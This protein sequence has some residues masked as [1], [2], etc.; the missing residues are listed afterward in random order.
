MNLEKI[1]SIALLVP[2]EEG[3]GLPCLFEGPPGVGKSARIKTAARVR[4]LPFRAVYMPSKQ[5]EDLTGL[6][7]PDRKGEIRSVCGL[8]PVRELNEEG[9]GVLLFDEVNWATRATQSALLSVVL[10]RQVGDTKIASGVRLLLAA[11]AADEGDGGVA[12]LTTLAN[13]VAHFRV[14]KPSADEYVAFRQ[15]AVEHGIVAIADAERVVEA[16]WPSVYPRLNGLLCGFFKGRGRDLVHQ[17]PPVGAKARHRG[18]PSPRSWDAAIR[19]A[20]TCVAL[21]EEALQDEFLEACVGEGAAMEF[22]EFAREADLPEPAAMLRGD[23]APD[24][25]RLDICVAAYAALGEHV[26]AQRKDEQR[27]LAPRT[28]RLFLEACEAG[29][30]DLIAAPAK[31]LAKAGLDVACADKAVADAAR[32][33]FARFR[34]SGIAGVAA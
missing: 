25:R 22:A 13:R 28:W 15:G 7:V 3:A 4:E 29:M 30:A 19:A 27:R 14:P 26:A 23:W 18:W 5:P 16:R 24:R 8:A 10:E 17:Q 1:V 12:M 11:N 2:M 20:A 9:R 33:V 31:R 6:P 21:G 34:E 32:P